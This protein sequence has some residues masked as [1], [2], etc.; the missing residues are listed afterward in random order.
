ML[1]YIQ[2]MLATQANH[3]V[4][5]NKLQKGC[6][7]RL[8]HFQSSA[9]R[10][11]RIMIVLEMEVLEE[12]GIFD[13]LGEPRSLAPLEDEGSTVAQPTT[14]SSAG[15]YG[16]QIPGQ[17]QNQQQQQQQRQQQYQSQAMQAYSSGGQGA[18]GV[19]PISPIEALSP[20]ANKWTIKARC[21]HKGEVKHWHKKNGEGKLFSLNLLDETGEIRATGFNEQCDNLYEVFQENMVY[22]ISSP[23]KVQIAKK[24]FSNLNND[25]ELTFERDTLVEKAEDQDSVPQVRFNFTSISDL[26]TVEAQTTIDTIGVLKEVGEVSQITSKTTSKPYDKRDL[27]LVDHSGYSVRLTVWGNS[28]TN[29]DVPDES[30]IAFKGVKVSDFGGRSLSL[31]SSGTMMVNPDITEAHKLKGWYEGGG[32]TDTFSSHASMGA[33]TGLGGKRDPP[34]TISQVKEENLGMTEETDYFS[35][36]GTIMYIKQETTWYPSCMSESCNKKVYEAEQG[37]WRCERCD[38]SWPKPQYRYILNLSVYDHTAQLWLSCFDDMG[39]VIMGLP[40]DELVEIK[41]NDD[42]AATEIFHQASG[43]PWVFRCRAKMDT[44]QDQQRVR[45]QIMN[46]SPI[47]WVDLAAKHTEV[48]GTY[49]QA[50]AY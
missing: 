32:R 42:H 25:Y 29:F 28:A 34:K 21:T 33:A 44:F 15:F 18:R 20:Y 5:E 39:R 17:N 43:K 27:T 2:C 26:Q 31:L 48:I 47:N 7:V 9:I 30:V 13:K 37:Q 14:I 50:V 19:H 49:D 22:Y 23:C 41:A 16:D 1:N 12:L 36:Y 6:I 24:Q 3:L 4:A 8:K 45:Y 38:K 46:V 10:G 40:A 11:K 35:L